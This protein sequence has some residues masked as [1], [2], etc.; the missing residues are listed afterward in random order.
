MKRKVTGRGYW[1]IVGPCVS[2]ERDEGHEEYLTGEPVT[3]P[4]Y[5]PGVPEC[6]YKILQLQESTRKCSYMFK[7]KF[8]PIFKIKS[9]RPEYA[10]LPTHQKGCCLYPLKNCMAT[11]EM[12][13]K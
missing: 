12:E 5:E 13:R 6:K 9:I 2:E 3:L 1:K 10:A 11:S 7:L 8:L 4:R